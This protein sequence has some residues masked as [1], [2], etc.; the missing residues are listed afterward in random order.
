MR[1][2]EVYR[3]ICKRNGGIDLKA[4]EQKQNDLNGK[5][6]SEQVLPVAIHA[7]EKE[8]EEILKK[9]AFDYIARGAGEEATL[10]AN[11]EAF[12]K[13]QISHRVLRDVTKRDL[14]I[15][16]FG[17]TFSSPI[18]FAPIGVQTIAHPEGELASARR[19]Q[20]WGFHLL[21]VQLLHIPWRK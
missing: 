11:R 7:W 8:A 1:L 19:Q 13:W 5:S 10:R 2:K 3:E 16:L 18:L 6:F 14:S 9:E 4:E 17:Q 12:G 15:S 20:R 21:Q